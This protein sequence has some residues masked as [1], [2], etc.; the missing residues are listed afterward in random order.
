MERTK[1]PSDQDI[2]CR[3]LP[4]SLRFICFIHAQLFVNYVNYVSVHMHRH[5]KHIWIHFYMLMRSCQNKAV[6][7]EIWLQW[8]VVFISLVRH[9]CIWVGR[10][11]KAVVVVMLVKVTYI[12]RAHMILIKHVFKVQSAL[13]LM[14]SQEVTL[15]RVQSL[16]RY[17]RSCVMEYACMHAHMLTHM[18][19]SST[20]MHTH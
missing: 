16:C 12:H 6:V 10:R 17:S 14:V 8:G 5:N 9:F 7:S 2:C 3:M 15:Q 4:V 13:K 20:G 18:E 1:L 11:G 19:C